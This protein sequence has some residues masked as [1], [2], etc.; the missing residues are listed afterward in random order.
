MNKLNCTTHGRRDSRV[1]QL[2]GLV[3]AARCE[4]NYR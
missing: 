2:G 1:V 3:H 4:T